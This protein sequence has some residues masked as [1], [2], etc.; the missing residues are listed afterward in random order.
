ATAQRSTHAIAR[1][2]A[3]YGRE[4]RSTLQALGNA[5]STQRELASYRAQSQRTAAAT[6]QAYRQA[7]AQRTQRALVA[8]ERRLREKEST[9]AFDLGKRDGARRMLLQLKLRELHLD[10]ARRATLES[11]LAA[12]DRGEAAA[13]AAL[14][15]TDAAQLG[16]YRA[17]LLARE[18]AADARMAARIARDSAANFATRKR[19]TPRVAVQATLLRGYS[20]SSDAGTV[21]DTIART[22]TDLRQRFAQLQSV[23]RSSA[24]DTATRIAAIQADRRALYRSIVATIAADARRLARQRHLTAVRL[25]NTRPPGSI[26]I[27]PDLRKLL[28]AS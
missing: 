18:S 11:Q 23:N 14:Q 3:R 27:T 7:M 28:S 25:G 21:S 5:R 4:E 26:D 19:L 2:S 1:R 10:K 22:G 15:Q 24:D 8:R 6:L 12:M 16:A 17:S 20:A 9:L 13:I